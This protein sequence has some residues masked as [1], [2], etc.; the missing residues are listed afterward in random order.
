MMFMEKDKNSVKPKT[1]IFARI[2][3]FLLSGQKRKIFIV[4]IMTIIAYLGWQ[5]FLAP[6]P[7][8]QYQTAIAEKGT[9]II[10]VAA[11]GQ[12]SATNNTSVSTQAS[13]VVKNVFVQ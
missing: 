10:S 6:K 4:I 1:E 12:V 13:G 5:N 11:S 9:L 3:N 7:Q 8:P 2:R